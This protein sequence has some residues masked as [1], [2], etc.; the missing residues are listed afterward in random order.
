[1]VPV[2]SKLSSLNVPPQEYSTPIKL[3]AVATS[4]ISQI[5]LTEL[6][7]LRNCIILGS[8]SE[9]VFD[10]GLAKEK[11]DLLAGGLS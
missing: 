8:D 6:A 2:Q 11:F 10:Y 3:C 5:A 1:M 7:L 4:L 9:I